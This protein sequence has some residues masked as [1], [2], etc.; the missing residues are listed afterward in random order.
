MKNIFGNGKNMKI[1]I[2]KVSVLII[3]FLYMANCSLM[4]KETKDNKVDVFN[5]I[6]TSLR[7]DFPKHFLDD[8]AI[9]IEKDIEQLTVY[10][11]PNPPEGFA[12]PDPSGKY[13]LGIYV[14]YNYERIKTFSTDISLE[15]W[16]F[17]EMFHLH[18][19]R[20]GEYNKFIDKAFPDENDPLVKWIKKDS[21]HKTFAREEAFINLVTFA[22]PARKKEQKEAVREFFNYIGA[23]NL[24][25]DEIESKL[26]IVAHN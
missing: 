16:I 7:M 21:Y 8:V 13:K 3:V 17:H 23:K 20:T 1:R 24:K 10:G 12:G 6:V 22:D 4:P 14:P 11:E 5:N 19:R 9:R 2:F 25:I 26:N 15:Q 18:N